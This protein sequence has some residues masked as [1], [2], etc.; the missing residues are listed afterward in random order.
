MK[1]FIV[2]IAA[3]FAA[4]TMMSAQSM[5]DATET[6]KIANEALS[7]GDYQTALSGFREALKMAEACGDEGLELVSTCKNIIPKTINALAVEEFQAQN[8]DAAAAHFEEAAAVAAE[9]GDEETASKAAERIP[10]VYAEK[11]KALIS[12]ND[13]DGAIAAFRKALELDPANGNTALRLGQV[14]EQTGKGEEAV[15]AYKAAA[16]GGQEANANTKLATFYLKQAQSL[17]GEKKFAEAV[18]AANTSYGYKATPQALK[19]AGLA[20]QNGKKNAEAIK[21]FEQYL[22]TN[23]KDANDINRRIAYLY[24]QS[25]NKAKAKE[26]FTKIADDP[27]YGAE[28]KQQLQ[29]IK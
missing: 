2:S 18:D 6:A 19:M 10:Q 15:E 29:A 14:L 17:L 16:A 7:S 9:Y 20:S 22:E 12:A 27:K 11:G 23:P 21:Y 24:L 8:F 5:A 28:A 26:F 1:R 4:A 13:Y 25:N 3:L